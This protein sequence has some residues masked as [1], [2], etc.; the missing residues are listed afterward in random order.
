MSNLLLL[1]AD[2]TKLAVLNGFRT[3]N[4]RIVEVLDLNSNNTQ[5][6]DLSDY[7][8]VTRGTHAGLLP[9]HSPVV[10][11]GMG[12]NKCFTFD[13]NMGGSETFPMN[14]QRMHFSGMTGSP[15]QASF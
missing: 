4:S 15:Y 9:D 10:C 8:L 6:E 5:C 12:T 13:F 11:G 2:C 1:I 7:P 14:Y 3:A